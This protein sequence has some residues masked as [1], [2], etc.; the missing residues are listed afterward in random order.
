MLRMSRRMLGSAFVLLTLPLAATAQTLTEAEKIARLE[1]ETELLQRQLKMLQGEIAKTKKKADKV[2]AAQAAAP[3]PAASAVVPVALTAPA[4]SAAT[5]GEA[6]PE[7]SGSSKDKPSESLSWH[8][9]TVYGTIDIGGAYQTAGAPISGALYLGLEYVPN[10]NAHGDQATIVGSALE[11]SKVGLKIEE[12]IGYGFTA[13]GKLQTDFNPWSGELTDAC[14]SIN[15]A[16]MQEY[17]G[18]YPSE[19]WNDGARCGQAFQLAYAGVSSPVFGTLTLG[20]QNSLVNDAIATYDP[21]HGSYAFSLIGYSG[22]SLGGIGSTETTKWDNSIKYIFTYGPLHAAGMYSSG[23]YDTAI[24]QEAAGAN[25]GFTYRGLSVDGF[26]TMTDGAVNLSPNTFSALSNNWLKATV[27]DNEAWTVMGKYTFDVP[28]VFG[29]YGSSK[30]CGFKD[31]CPGAT[32]TFFG[33]YNYTDMANDAYYNGAYINGET[34]ATTSGVLTTVGGYAAVYG[35]GLGD[36]Y[37]TDR[38]LETSW[39]GATYEMGP[40]ALT[41][42]YYHEAQNNYL[43]ASTKVGQPASYGTC[44]NTFNPSKNCAGAT[45]MASFLVD[46]TVNKHFDVYAGVSY[47]SL[48]GGF[49]N[50]SAVSASNPVEQF[51]AHETT[52]VVTGLRLRF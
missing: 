36:L 49:Q 52:N 9:V 47:A 12:S 39:V 16:A 51:P 43:L 24:M 14:A 20:R 50:S 42:A 2:E 13:I 32:M 6:R 30:D 46:Y 7:D 26:W 29:Y 40:W 15:R 18:G 48:T 19:A 23:G 38:I 17:K 34:A 22:S 31:E 4:Y 35:V 28:S 10:R 41:G 25:V 27:T 3:P 5:A 11:Q 21:M 33:G 1:Q 8:G 45:D 37:A 44:T